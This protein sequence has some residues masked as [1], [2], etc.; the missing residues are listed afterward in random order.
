MYKF[1]LQVRFKVS[2][3]RRRQRRK[4]GLVKS[5]NNTGC[6]RSLRSKDML[7]RNREGGLEGLGRQENGEE[8]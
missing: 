1:L 8:L 6:R 4:K 2:E 5:R 3:A 7:S